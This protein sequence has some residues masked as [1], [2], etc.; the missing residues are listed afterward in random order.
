MVL[1]EG[2]NVASNRGSNLCSPL[3]QQ[4]VSKVERKDLPLLIFLGAL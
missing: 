1:N 3:L 4:K 2:S